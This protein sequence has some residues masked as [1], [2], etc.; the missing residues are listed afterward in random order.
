MVLQI[1][2]RNS[3]VSELG[4]EV[5]F[6]ARVAYLPV[7]AAGI[8]GLRSL[9]WLTSVLASPWSSTLSSPES[10]PRRQARFD[11]TSTRNHA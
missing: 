11:W 3:G 9:I 5:Y 6:V 10:V 4:A 7:Y 2:G 1:L 8:Q